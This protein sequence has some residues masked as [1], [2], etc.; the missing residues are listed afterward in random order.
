MMRQR[1]TYAS[2]FPAGLADPVSAALATTL[3]GFDLVAKHEDLVVYEA[4]SGPGDIVRLPFVHNSFAV[5]ARLRSRGPRQLDAAVRDLLAELQDGR[6]LQALVR[7]RSRPRFRIVASVEN[8]LSAL[9]GQTLADTERTLTSLTGWSVSRAKPDVEFWFMV[10]REG[11]PMALVRLT[12][13]KNQHRTLAKGELRS[14]LAHLLC[15]LSE[16]SAEDVFLDPFCGSGAIAI[17]RSKLPYRAIFASD[18]DA[19]HI[20]R[21]RKAFR[22]QL[23][24]RS[25]R[26]NIRRDDAFALTRYT[27]GFVNKI[28]TDPPWGHYGELDDPFGFYCR[29]LSEIARIM[30]RDGTLILVTSRE[31]DVAGAARSIERGL[32]L[33]ETHEFLLSGQKA[34]V[35]KIVFPLGHD[36]PKD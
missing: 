27:P 24:R 31:I 4:R 36:Q 16:P 11:P 22:E 1:N 12:R 33:I 2:T 17:A 34:S 25:N 9:A 3:E 20:Q 29:V 35:H 28:V 30:R 6:G 14:N 18:S 15:E 21:L 26:F 7:G 10:R 13:Q 5:V 23:K 32:E 19:N 8:K